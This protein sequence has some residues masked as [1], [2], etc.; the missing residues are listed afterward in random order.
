MVATAKHT[1]THNQTFQSLAS[2]RQLRTVRLLIRDE[3]LMY[4][5]VGV[6]V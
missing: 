6:L 2:S 3:A 5:S 4:L 1:K